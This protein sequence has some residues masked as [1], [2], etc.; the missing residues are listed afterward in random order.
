MLYGVAWYMTKTRAHYQLLNAASLQPLVVETIHGAITIDDPLIIELIESP[1]VQRL[2]KIRQYGSNDY[3]IGH[4]REYSRFEHS[5]GVFY[6]LRIHGAPRNEQIAGLLHDASHTVFSHATEPLFSND[7]HEAYQDSIH[8]E[9][10][11]QYGIESILSKYGLEVEEVLPKN[12]C[13]RALERPLPLL[14]A[15]RIEYNFYAGIMDG[16]LT[17]DELHE[18][19]Q[20]LHFDGKYWYFDTVESAK[21]FAQIPLYESVHRWQSPEGM[22]LN[23]W[24]SEALKRAW[25]IGLI[26]SDDIHFNITDDAMWDYLMKSDDVYIKKCITKIMHYKEYFSYGTPQDHDLVLK[27]K[28]RGVDPLVAT[29]AGL[30]YLSTLDGEFKAEY[31]RVKAMM[32]EG[33]CIKFCE[34]PII[35]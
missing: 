21:K 35:P 25:D 15:D 14:C 34:D 3:V 17:L 16:L 1:A 12:E 13:F 19:H 18:L 27:G 28:F 24:I 31:D 9:F 22:I 11:K 23:Q 30:Q 4:S 10:L 26:N 8:E 6:L 5:L 2:K 33:W 32:E 20:Q 7:V 29:D